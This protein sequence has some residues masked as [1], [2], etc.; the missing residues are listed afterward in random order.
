[1]PKRV[2]DFSDSVEFSGEW[3]F[4]KTKKERIKVKT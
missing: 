4:V 1:M 3:E 2:I